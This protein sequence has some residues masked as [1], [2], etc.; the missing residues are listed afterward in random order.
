VTV[1]VFDELGNGK[2]NFIFETIKILAHEMNFGYEDK[3]EDVTHSLDI[4][5][6]K[7]K[8][9]EGEFSDEGK[10]KLNLILM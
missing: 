9:I 7:V 6:E 2:Y 4:T 3:N 8:R 10:R 1:Q 5:Y